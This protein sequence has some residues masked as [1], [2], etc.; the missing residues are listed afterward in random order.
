MQIAQR[1]YCN[2][3]NVFQFE[4]Q[5]LPRTTGSP[6]IIHLETVCSYEESPILELKIDLC[7]FDRCSIPHGHGIKAQ[8]LANQHVFSMVASYWGHLIAISKFPNCFLTNK[9]NGKS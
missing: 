6:Q 3:F 4:K 7:T 9:V 2:Y 8:A 5:L 1:K